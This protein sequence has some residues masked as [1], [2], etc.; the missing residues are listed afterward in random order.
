MFLFCFDQ[1]TPLWPTLSR[2]PSFQLLAFT[3]FF[4]TMAADLSIIVDSDQFRVFGPNTTVSPWTQYLQDEMYK[5]TAWYAHDPGS[6]IFYFDGVSQ[7]EYEFS[8]N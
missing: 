6:F 8:D 7:I 4:S 2:L 3:F 5:G 1:D